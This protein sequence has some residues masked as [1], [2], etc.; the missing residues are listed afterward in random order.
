MGILFN[1]EGPG[2]P[3]GKVLPLIPVIATRHKSLL[4][5]LEER[6]G[7][8][9]T[10]AWVKGLRKRMGAIETRYDK[11]FEIVVKAHVTADDVRGRWVIGVFPLHLAAV[12]DRVTTITLN[13]PQ[14]LRG[15]E[16][17]VEQL[18][19]CF[20][21]V[22]TYEVAELMPHAIDICPVCGAD[23]HADDYNVHCSAS[24]TPNNQGG[25]DKLPGG[26][27]LPKRHGLYKPVK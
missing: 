25:L 7:I 9:P 8:L 22:A 12:A 19:S 15:T 3:V 26:H 10:P 23:I 4:Q 14:E 17:S 18:R 11:Y 1:D 5:F 16:L 13:V 24:F 21:G 27:E 20:D 2:F 6:G